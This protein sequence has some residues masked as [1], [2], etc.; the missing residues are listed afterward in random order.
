MSTNPELQ[1]TLDE[2]VAE[3]LGLLTGLDLTYM[4]ELDRY[5]A[6]TRQINR[7]L[8]H[9]A[10]E[11]EWSFYA[12][13]LSLGQPSPGDREVVLPISFR[14]RI[15]SDDAVRLVNDEGQPVRWAYFLPRDALHKYE[16]RR[17]LWCSITRQALVFSRPITD[18]E[19][20]L[21]VVVPVMREPKMN[22]L[23][24]AG[25]TVPNVVRKQLIDFP[26]PDA[27]TTRAAYL[28]AQTDPVMQPRVPTLEGGYKDVMYQLM[29]RDK[30]NTDTPYQNDFILPVESGLYASGESHWHPHSSY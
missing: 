22:R 24:E 29:E 2:A 23:P 25:K 3:V 12:T 26:Y 21:E 16:G 4:P 20:E 13:T 1:T 27:I 7:A 5:R 14:A 28:Y 11:N 6:I 10:L 19:S 17:G 18:A 8:R 15:I 30:A 9:N